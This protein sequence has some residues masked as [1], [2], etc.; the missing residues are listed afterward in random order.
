MVSERQRRQYLEAMGISVWM[1]RRPI[2]HALDAPLP[3]V[4]EAPGQ[5]PGGHG[6]R[7]HALLDNIERASGSEIDAPSTASSPASGAASGLASDAAA[8]STSDTASDAPSDVHTPLRSARALL[9][10][11]AASPDAAEPVSQRPIEQEP[12]G[13]DVD[14]TRQAGSSEPL[15][16]TIQVAALEGRW[17]LLLARERGLE[18][19]EQGLLEAALAAADIHSSKTLSFERFGWPMMEGLPAVDALDEARQGFRAF[20]AGRRAR[21]W[22]PERILLFGRLPVLETVLDIDQATSRLLSLPFWQG[23]SLEALGAFEGRREL[24]RLM[25]PWRQWWHWSENAEG[26]GVEH[27][28]E[29]EQGADRADE[30]NGETPN[31]R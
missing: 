1:A 19:H 2:P 21:G 24:W 7:L 6:E 20:L 16:F 23:P 28:G 12:S 31:E 4:E 9:D 18:R 26:Q 15:R 17:L 22:H 3:P 13:V 27:Q 8:A 10:P 14:S 11:P 5:A 25:A 30:A 29:G